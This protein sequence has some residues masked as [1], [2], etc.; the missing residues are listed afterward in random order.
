VLGLPLVLSMPSDSARTNRLK[1]LGDA[2]TPP[3]SSSRVAL[4]SLTTF[5]NAACPFCCVLD[6]LNRPELNPTDEK[7][8]ERMVASRADGCTI[9]GFT[10][11]EPTVHPRFAEF[12]RRGR[13]LGYESITINTNG[14]QFKSRAWTEAAL[15]AGLSHIDFSIHGEGAEMHDAMMARPGAFEAFRRGM[16]HLRELAPRYRP[17]L[18]ATTVVTAQ[19]ASR[20]PAIAAML[21]D[22]GIPTLRFKHCFEGAEGADVALVAR[23]TDLMGYVREAVRVARARGAMVTLTHFPLCLLGEE[24]VFA[25]DLTEENILSINRDGAVLLDGRASDHRRGAASVCEGCALA[26]VCTKLD[27]RYVAVHGEAELHPVANRAALR[28]F[29]ERGLERHPGEPMTNHV[30]RLLGA[31]AAAPD[32]RLP[33]L[34]SG[35]DSMNIGFISPTFRVLEMNWEHDYEMVKLGIPTVMGHLY[36]LGHRDLEHWDFDAQICEACAVDANAFDLRQY[37]DQA[38][39]TGFLQGTDDTLR[40]QTEKLLDVLGVTEKA[41]FG[42]SLSAVLDRIVNVM[43][44]AAMS[45]CLAKVLRE[46]YPKSSIVVGG[47]QASPDSTQPAIYQRIMDECPAIDYAFVGHVEAITVQVFRNLWSGEPARNRTLGPRVIY[48][49]EDGSVRFGVDVAEGQ[50]MGSDILVLSG[51]RKGVPEHTNVGANA[52][53]AAGGVA[54]VAPVIIAAEQLMK[55]R[56]V[57]DG[58]KHVPA[59]ADSKA[60]DFERTD[61]SAAEAGAHPYDTIPAAVPIFDPK[62]VE[63]FRYSGRQIMKRF[64]FDKET[65]L[66]YSR[67]ENDQIVVLP[68]IF[69]RGC[70]APCGFCSYAYT[71]IEGED[72]AQT[73]AGLR[74][75][76]E[77]YNCKHFHF[78]N[79]QINSVYKYA[80]MFCDALIDQK[81]D[82]LW[83]DCCNM[84]SLD[85]HLLEKMRKAGA[86]RLVFGVES[87]EDSMLRMINKGMNTETIE[88]LLKAS[89]ELG[90]WNHVL[91]IAGMPHESKPKQ[92]RIMEFLERTAPTVDF[93]SVSSYYL[94]ATSPWSKN[95][96][97]FGIERITDPTKF[98][99]DQ[100]FNEI[101]GGKWESE[102][103]RWPE[104]KQQII[105]STQRFYKTITRAKGQSRCVAGNIDLYLLMFL[106]SALG[107]D[108][109]EE[110]SKLYLQTAK[111]IFPGQGPEAEKGEEEMPRNRFRV[112]I[113]YI[114]GRV[115]EADQFSQVDIP[116]DFDVLPISSGQRGFAA[117]ARYTFT[118]R[119]PALQ[120]INDEGTKQ[121]RKGLADNLP[122]LVAQ[123]TRMLGP[124][125]QTLDG[126][127]APTTTERMAELAAINLPRYKPFVNEGYTV[128]GPST[129]RTIMERNLEWSGLSS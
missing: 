13:E 45:Q 108:R 63:H 8:I 77:T 6:I 118:W 119:S 60:G 110:I 96:E 28:D 1:V 16:A 98:L 102:G 69:I 10:G 72:L 36:R 76:S 112:H 39:V 35:S 115:N 21:V 51:L 53:A 70:N 4:I 89:H 9:L 31:P 68:H 80:E 101:P 79:T 19:N 62:L 54:G 48:R 81:L 123:L 24:A 22:E 67:F 20:L 32:G 23:Y 7:I 18:G 109:K 74:F 92:D 33:L 114:M 3:R 75:L 26:A 56:T 120:S 41:I 94:I 14:I 126:R 128:T 116:V 71:K 5:C 93:Y 27:Q 12:C 65:A 90:I 95:P 40:A 73:V 83:S 15:A 49:A 87:P 88:R 25:T 103:L 121:T 91:L 43:A 52:M 47:L 124:F 57:V 64:H 105:D 82:I 50:Q 85:E 127:L 84:R 17:V 99:E 46:R 55:R 2:P 42:I 78:L 129:Q 122:Q 125:L 29:L 37:F 100:A 104:K 61:L 38:L 86:M 66:R 107:H 44:L 113:P 106:Y 59:P 97:K 58:T 34:V 30:R 111:T 117:S 11:G